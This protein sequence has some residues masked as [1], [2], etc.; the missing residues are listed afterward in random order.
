MA[1]ELDEA[2]DLALVEFDGADEL[3]HLDASA[4]ELKA[5]RSQTRLRD[6][7]VC[8]KRSACLVANS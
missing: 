5:A 2:L 4:R 1:D 3:G 6:F 8:S 7:A